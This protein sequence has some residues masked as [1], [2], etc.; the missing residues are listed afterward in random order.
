MTRLLVAALALLLVPGAA[1]RTHGGALYAYVS[2]EHENEVAVVD[3]GQRRVL[4]RIR[5]ARGPHNVAAT[6]FRDPDL[7]LVTSPPAGTVTVLRRFREVVKVFR[8]LRSPHDVEVSPDNRWAYVTEEHGSRV[9]VLSLT[10]LR[11]AGAVRVM[12]GPHDLAVRRGGREVWVTHGSSGK[13][14]TVLDTS[15]PAR[16]RVAARI[17]SAGAPHDIAF[18]PS[19][20]QAW[21]TYWNSPWVGLFFADGR[22]LVRRVRVGTLPHHVLV[23]RTVWVTDHGSGRAYLLRPHD[24]RRVV[25]VTV[26]SRPHHVAILQ[27]RAAVV[28]SEENTLVVFDERSGRRVSAPLRVGE[29]PHGVALIWGP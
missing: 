6:R 4:D 24:G 18:A 20:K 10:R 29:H 1:A 25:S 12:A 22:R 26:G 3:V 5:V 17:A 7:V 27:G 21:I 19:G 23:G 28:S 14:V 13:A 16:P 11:I 15:R 8:G 9:L 2:L